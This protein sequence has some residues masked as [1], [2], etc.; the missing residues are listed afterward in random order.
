MNSCAIEFQDGLR[1]VVS[2]NALRKA[3]AGDLLPPNSI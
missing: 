2:R 1:A 3:H